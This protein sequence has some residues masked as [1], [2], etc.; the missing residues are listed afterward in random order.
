MHAIHA[1]IALA[2]AAGLAFSASANAGLAI[3]ATDCTG[4]TADQIQALMPNCEQGTRY[5]SDF[6]NG[7]LYEG[8]YDL[9]GVQRRVV[10]GGG[11]KTAAVASRHYN[12]YQPG[13]GLYNTFQ[14]YQDVYNNN[15]HVKAAEAKA[16][17]NLDLKPKVS[18]GDDGYMNAYDASSADV[19]NSAV[20]NWLE[21]TWFTAGKVQGVVGPGIGSPRLDDMLANLFNTIKTSKLTVD[22]V[23]QITIVFHDGSEMTYKTDS[24]GN[25]V[26]VPGTAVDAHGN[27]IPENYHDLAGTGRQTY[28]INGN[29]GYDGTNLR[30]LT[31]LYGA[32]VVHN[33]TATVVV[34]SMM[35]PDNKVT[36]VWPK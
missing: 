9:T 24:N 23:V 7:N 18:L 35:G 21:T 8:C 6:A 25:W 27:H 33:P 3:H 22:F 34:C 17:V 16:Y 15:G 30:T 14:A 11:V 20:A 12:W 26:K 28:V 2:V 31:N 5:V 13:A 10:T 32:N 1:S 36:C 29:P 4:C 19:N